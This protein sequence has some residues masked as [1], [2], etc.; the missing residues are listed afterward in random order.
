MKHTG[1]KQKSTGKSVLT[2]KS[3]QHKLI[4]GT[5]DWRKVR[6]IQVKV[7]VLSVSIRHKLQSVNLIRDRRKLLA[8]NGLCL[9]LT[10]IGNQSH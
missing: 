3:V 5:L 9:L 4:C 8:V 6:K 10:E 2:L 1:E 7:K